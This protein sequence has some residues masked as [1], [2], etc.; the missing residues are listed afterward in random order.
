MLLTCSKNDSKR[1]LTTMDNII[2]PE[3][4][5]TVNATQFPTVKHNSLITRGR[6]GIVTPLTNASSGLT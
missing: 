3:K 6:A 1:Y 4:H 5:L 2:M